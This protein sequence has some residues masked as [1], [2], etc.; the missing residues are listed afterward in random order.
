MIYE[1]NQTFPFAAYVANLGK[2]TEGELKEELVRFPTTKEHMADV[3]KRIGIGQKRPDGALYEEV[4][5]T[6]Y[7]CNVSSLSGYLTEYT[8]LNELNYLAEKIDKIEDG[9]KEKFEAL[10]EEGDSIHNAKDVINLTDNLNN[11]NLI[12]AKSEEDLGIYIIHDVEEREIPEWLNDY[13]DYEGYGRDYAIN[14]GATLTSK[15]YVYSTGYDTEYYKAADD[16]P[17][18]SLVTGFNEEKTEKMELEAP[19]EAPR[20]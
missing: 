13:I 2:Y 16:I 11:Y 6:G 15:G 12:N 17:Q 9:S 3:L 18:E 20:M 1:N 7:E 4:F 19:E 5:V 8:N 14:E 10:L